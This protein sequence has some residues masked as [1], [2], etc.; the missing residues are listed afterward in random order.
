MARKQHVEA[1]V[2]TTVFIAEI[3]RTLAVSLASLIALASFIDFL[4]HSIATS[5]HCVQAG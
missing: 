1:S 4:Y 3:G 5:N 2:G